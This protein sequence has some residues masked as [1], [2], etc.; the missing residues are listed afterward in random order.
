M[1]K[2]QSSFV[3]LLGCVCLAAGG[4]QWALSIQPGDMLVE[5]GKPV[6]IKILA[7]RSLEVRGLNGIVVENFKPPQ[8]IQIRFATGEVWT[9]PAIERIDQYHCT[10]TFRGTISDSTQ[11]TIDP[12][13]NVVRSV[14]K[15]AG[16]YNVTVQPST[17]QPNPSQEGLRLGREHRAGEIP[18]YCLV[19]ALRS[20][21]LSAA[22]REAFLESFLS[23][24]Q[25]AN[26]IVA[27]RKYTDVLRDAII[28][29]TFEQG[30]QDGVLHANN[31]IND[32]YV[33]TLIGNAGVSGAAALA[34]KAGYIDGFAEVLLTKNAAIDR[35]DALR[36]AETMYDS[37]KRGMGL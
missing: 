32:S 7:A 33:Q 31:Q 13:A 15:G 27:G 23:V 4:C 37:L 17:S 14:G 6:Q 3:L 22:D 35:E 2:R 34:W 30:R 36:Q 10:Y 8:P 20:E 1:M 12:N 25:D 16:P 9:R 29:S 28:G 21:N 26:D 19:I 18:T 11:Y 24:Y 5:P